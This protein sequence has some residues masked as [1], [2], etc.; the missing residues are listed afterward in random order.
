MD[1]N[2]TISNDSSFT[3]YT[4]EI[5]RSIHIISGQ[6][7]NLYKQNIDLSKDISDLDKEQ[8]RQSD[9]LYT[10]QLF[11]QIISERFVIED[12]QSVMKSPVEANYVVSFGTFSIYVYH[13]LSWL[14]RLLLKMCLGCKIRKVK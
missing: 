14:R 13:K 5:L 4:D 2:L 3:S 10:L 8:S 6:I 7:D 11:R 12:G 9:K 1:Q